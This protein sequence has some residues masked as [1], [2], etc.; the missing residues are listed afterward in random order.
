[1]VVIVAGSAECLADAVINSDFSKGDFAALGWKVDGAWDVFDYKAADHNPGSVARF[2]ANKPDGKLSKTFEDVKDPKKLTLSSDVG[3]GWG[4][5]DQGSD[6]ISFM[7]LDSK[8]NGYVF[9]TCRAKAKWAVQW[10]KVE[11]STPPKDMTWAT[12]EIDCTHKAVRDG[13]GLSHIVVSR[14]AGGNW[15]I[16]GKDWNQGAGASVKFTDDTTSSF[17]QVVFLGTQNFDEQDV[18]NVALDI[19]K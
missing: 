10:A 11:N 1:L 3:W 6:N 7:L 14:D 15:T 2:A 5:A 16:T 17:S 4:A 19:T 13:G 9:K 12:E 8:G 18:D